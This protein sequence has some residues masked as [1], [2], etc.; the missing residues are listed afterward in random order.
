MIHE[1]DGRS[2]CSVEAVSSDLL[3]I[4]QSKVQS[5]PLTNAALPMTHRPRLAAHWSRDVSLRPLIGGY[6][7]KALTFEYELIRRMVNQS[8][9]FWVLQNHIDKEMFFP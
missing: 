5:R 4:S 9:K 7:S 6:F 2:S 8:H 1:P 3:T